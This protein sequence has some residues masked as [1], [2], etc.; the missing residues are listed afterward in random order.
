MGVVD[1]G[2]VFDSEL[3]DDGNPEIGASPLDAGSPSNDPNTASSPSSFTA[4]RLPTCG[5]RST[6]AGARLGPDDKFTGDTASL[7][8]SRLTSCT[9]C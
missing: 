2:D 6:C 1:G 9:S 7:A 5:A 4:I 8:T 3:D